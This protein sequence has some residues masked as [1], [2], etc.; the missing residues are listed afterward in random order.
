MGES[1]TK[2]G[3]HLPRV[4]LSQDKVLKRGFRKGMS[5][6]SEKKG[7]RRRQRPLPLSG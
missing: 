1:I 2:R 3:D 6:H 5:T 4:D 7:R